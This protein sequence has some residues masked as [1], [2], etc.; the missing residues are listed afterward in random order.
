MVE[1]YVKS[2]SNANTDSSLENLR[3]AFY[4]S[5]SFM[6][7]TAA[8]VLIQCYF[9]GIEPLWC[10]PTDW[11]VVGPNVGMP[12]KRQTTKKVGAPGQKASKKKVM[13][14]KSRQTN[15][16]SS[17]RASMESAK[18]SNRQT[19]QRQLKTT[20]IQQKSAKRQS[21]SGKM[22]FKQTTKSGKRRSSSE[23]NKHS[24]RSIQT[25][26]KQHSS[27]RRILKHRSR[28]LSSFG[29]IKQKMSRRNLH[30]QQQTRRS[31]SRRLLKKM[32]HG[33][34][35]QSYKDGIA[36]YRQI[37]KSLHSVKSV[38]QYLAQDQ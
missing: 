31:S 11:I 26:S 36:F 30:K 3:T 21:S 32:R 16:S 1:S 10:F 17:N 38:S 35:T 5:L 24:M 27:S 20:E 14:G 9:Y 4:I 19:L 2:S 7:L 25:G 13:S 15:C 12:K 37:L 18:K 28:S 34:K 29:K 33:G 8:I 23:T 22:L 6:I